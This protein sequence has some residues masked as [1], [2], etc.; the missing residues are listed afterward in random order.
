MPIYRHISLSRLPIDQESSLQSNA[1]KSSN[2][3]YR[4]TASFIHL[5]LHTLYGLARRHLSCQPSTDEEW[6]K[7]AHI[8]VI[9]RLCWVTTF[10]ILLR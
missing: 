1:K 4:R 8:H 10:K 5:G 3:V 6:W 7:K 2:D 9:L